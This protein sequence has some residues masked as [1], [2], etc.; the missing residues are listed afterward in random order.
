MNDRD[1]PALIVAVLVAVNIVM[2]L[3]TA[4]APC[5]GCPCRYEPGPVR[6]FGDRFER[7][8]ARPDSDF[9]LGR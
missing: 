8:N 1:L 3:V 7:E 4:H 5:D 6:P 9:I 2:T